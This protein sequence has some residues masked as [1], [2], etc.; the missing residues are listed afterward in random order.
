MLILQEGICMIS[1]EW[2]L[3]PF[4]NQR[5][6]EFPFAEFCCGSF[7]FLYFVSQPGLDT[8][9]V[10]TH[11]VFRFLR[12]CDYHVEESGLHWNQYRMQQEVIKTYKNG[13]FHFLSFLTFFFSPFI[14]GL[15]PDQ[16]ILLGSW[17]E[18]KQLK[19]A[20]GHVCHTGPRQC[21]LLGF[22]WQARLPIGGPVGP[23]RWSLALEERWKGG[24]VERWEGGRIEMIRLS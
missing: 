7:F 4:V 3:L 23:F 20:W 19:S 12:L 21:L 2:T 17:D 15:F 14:F 11:C 8:H 22:L 18:L 9:R 1:C 16:L 10:S 13:L 6:S 5:Y 24:K